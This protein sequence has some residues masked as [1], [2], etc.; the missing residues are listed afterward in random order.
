MNLYD[1]LERTFATPGEPDLSELKTVLLAL[2]EDG[3]RHTWHGHRVP[4]WGRDPCARKLRR[5]GEREQ[6]YC[7]YLFPREHVLATATHLGHVRVDPYR[8]NLLNL[9]LGRNDSL[10]NN[11]EEHLL[12]MNMGNVDWRPLI[13][14]WSGLEYLSKY[15]AL[16]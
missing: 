10:L 16:P 5:R 8:Q 2:I 14:L 4:T 1:H 7:R 12:L 3:Q 11:F 13:N 9:F 6:V 15:T